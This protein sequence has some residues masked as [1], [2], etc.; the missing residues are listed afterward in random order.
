MRLFA[1]LF[2]LLCA[3]G[4]SPAQMETTPASEPPQLHNNG[5]PMVLDYHCTDDDIRLSGLTCTA[6]DPCPIYLELA[7]AEAVGNRI[8]AAGNIHSSSRTLASL[9]LASDD[10]GKTWHEP[11]ERIRLAGLDRIQFIDF[12]SGWV[13]GETQHPLPKDPF[14]LATTDGGKTWLQRPIFAEP[15]F[16]AILQFWFTSRSNGRMVLD[17]GLTGESG[18]FELYETNN[19]GES[20]MLRQTSERIIELLSGDPANAAQRLRA[21]G[22]SKSFHIERRA[23]EAWKN[24]AAFSVAIGSCSAPEVPPPN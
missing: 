8:F 1:G 21:D 14:L 7:S 24:V 18:R 17:R 19:G 13:S 4:L 9:L 16:G 22:A 3:A 20:W 6:E 5:K 23:H 15:Q 11:Y 2:A 12:E 10:D